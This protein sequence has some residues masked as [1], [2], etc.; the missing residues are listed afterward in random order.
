[1]ADLSLANVPDNTS[2]LN[3]ILDERRAELNFE[4]HRL[5]DLAR[6]GNVAAILG[7]SVNPIMPIPQREIDGTDNI[8]CTKSGILMWNSGKCGHE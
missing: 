7:A 4:G 1:M 6:T 5:F 3:A 2:Y 8:G